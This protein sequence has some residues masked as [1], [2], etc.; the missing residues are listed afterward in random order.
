MLQCWAESFGMKKLAREQDRP[1]G[2]PAFFTARQA[3]LRARE[4]GVLHHAVRGRVRGVRARLVSA[5]ALCRL[6]HAQAAK[7]GR[8]R[9]RRRLP[10]KYRAAC[11]P[12]KSAARE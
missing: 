5:I 11:T 12:P 8:A 7:R 6:G 3:V 9:D 10:S 4:C 2:K 1:P